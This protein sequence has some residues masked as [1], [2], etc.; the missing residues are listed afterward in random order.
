[1]REKRDD[2][3]SLQG[4][5]GFYSDGGG[6]YMEWW[7]LYMLSDTWLHNGYIIEPLPNVCNHITACQGP[8]YVIKT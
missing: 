5:N 4:E 7:G 2:I 6:I 3:I 8:I 1:M